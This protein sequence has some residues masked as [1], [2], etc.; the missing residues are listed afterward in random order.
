M[1]SQTGRGE[2]PDGDGCSLVGCL[3]YHRC[4]EC[5]TRPCTCD[6]PDVG[7]CW[8]GAYG[9]PG[10]VHVAKPSPNEPPEECGRFL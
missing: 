3:L 2:C 4:G 5:G 7:V 1:Y 10:T 9:T 8:C 6:D